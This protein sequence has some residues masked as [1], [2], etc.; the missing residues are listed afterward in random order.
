MIIAVDQG[1]KFRSGLYGGWFTLEA[2][3]RPRPLMTYINL[4]RQ[5][6]DDRQ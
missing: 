1:N 3:E 6:C 5:C 2:S 4:K